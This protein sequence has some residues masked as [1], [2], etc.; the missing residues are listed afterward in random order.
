MLDTHYVPEHLN[1]T[2]MCISFVSLERAGR[3][4]MVQRGQRMLRTGP[5]LSR[6]LFRDPG[7]A[8]RHVA[9]ASGSASQGQSSF[10]FCCFP[11]GRLV[12]NTTPAQR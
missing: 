12:I 3:S 4:L 11:V 10:F 1:Q 6:P 9:C 2:S 8:F 7:I 5:W